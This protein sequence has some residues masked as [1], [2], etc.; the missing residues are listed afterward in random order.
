MRRFILCTALALYFG[1][2]AATAAERAFSI[3]GA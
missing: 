3:D 2:F 1:T